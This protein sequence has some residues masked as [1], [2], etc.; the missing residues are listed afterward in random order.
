[1]KIVG[2]IFKRGLFAYQS[3]NHTI[4]FSMLKVAIGLFQRFD[5]R[6]KIAILVLDKRQV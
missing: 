3:I 4:K 2:L 5:F 6:S 1:M